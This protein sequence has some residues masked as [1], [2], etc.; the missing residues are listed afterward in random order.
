MTAERRIERLNSL[1]KE[2]IN[3]V[4][5]DD[6]RN[7]KMAKLISVAKVELTKDLSIAKVFVSIIEDD[8]T[9]RK[10]TVSMLNKAAG[11]ISVLSSKKM[12]IKMF[13][14]LKFKLD[15]T[16]DSQMNIH[17]I[18]QEIANKRASQA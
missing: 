14:L 10:Q 2:V 4:I 11:F 1:L 6:I 12:V 7:P 17:N 5:R 8:E 15:T 18:L 13:P 9:L 16:V 3:E